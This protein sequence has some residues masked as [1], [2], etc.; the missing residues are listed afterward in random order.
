MTEHKDWPGL[1]ARLHG[2]PV[3]LFHVIEDVD[4]IPIAVEREDLGVFIDP[5]QLQE[6]NNE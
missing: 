4:G 5:N 2:Q 1:A 3:Y 6:D